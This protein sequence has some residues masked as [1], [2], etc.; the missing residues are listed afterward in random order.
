M[1]DSPCS[2]KFGGL[3]GWREGK[4]PYSDRERWLASAPRIAGLVAPVAEPISIAKGTPRR[5]TVRLH[6]NG[7]QTISLVA[8]EDADIRA[9]GV[10]GYIRPIDRSTEK[11][12]YFLTC[13]GRSCDGLAMTIVIGGQ[14]PVEFILLGSRTGLP[15]SGQPLLAAR[16]KF[17]R[18]Q[19]SP[20]ATITMSRV[21][22]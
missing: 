4:L 13:S 7:A 2:G 20:D 5:V 11:D 9:A 16:P 22:L 1:T 10:A 3:P 15:P 8:L 17:A 12:R 14:K 21:R 6:A 18:P 19:Y